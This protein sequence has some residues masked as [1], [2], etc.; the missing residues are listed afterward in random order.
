MYSLIYPSDCIPPRLYTT[1]KAHKTEKNYPMRAVV[2]TIGSPVYGTS[3][4]FVKI[5]QPTLN[6]NKQRVVN[7]SSFAEEAKEWNISSSEIQT[8][9]NV[10]NLYPSVPIDQAVAVIT[11]ILNNDTDDLRKPT[12]LTLTDIHKLIELCLST[13]C[14]IFHNCVCI[15]ENSG[16]IGLALMVLISEALL[17]RLEHRTLQADLAT[18][19][20]LLTYK[21]YV[22]DSHARFE[23]VDQSHSFLNIL[24][25]QNKA[26]K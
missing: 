18:N 11:E 24:N 16:P 13:N 1:L 12:K 6:K 26:I 23:I 22:D 17:Q 5:I 4:Y 7:S 9:F 25:T 21:R 19:L 2:S 10:V 3:K 20:A 14:F 15:L 8:S